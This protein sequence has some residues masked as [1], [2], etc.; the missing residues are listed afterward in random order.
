[1]S[2]SKKPDLSKL[3]QSA[4]KIGSQLNAYRLPIFLTLIALVYVFIVYQ[5]HSLSTAEPSPDA[6]SSQVKGA[7]TLKLDPKLVRQLESLQDNSVSVQTLFDQARSN[8]FQ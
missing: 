6:V 8:P 1:M 5:I 4:A 3:T 2:E 7:E